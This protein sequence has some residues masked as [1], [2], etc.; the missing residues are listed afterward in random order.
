[1]GFY[2]A[3]KYK[4]FTPFYDWFITQTMPEFEIK[5]RVISLAKLTENEKVL[6]F[7][8]GTG[9]LAKMCLEHYPSIDFIGLDVDPKMIEIANNKNINGLKSVL[10]DGVTI[11]FPGHYF[12]RVL[13]TWVFH[14]LTR[15]Q[16]IIAFKEIKRVL[17]PDGLF[18]LADWGKPSN[19]LQSLLFFILQVFDTFNQTVDNVNGQIPSLIK[20]SGFMKIK[21]KGYMNTLFG[22]LRYWTSA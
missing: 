11:P 10:F 15:K 21:S 19:W 2:P 17:K 14:H 18:V 13:S 7:G 4:V 1:M 6:D 16:K 5:N 12:D 8:S 22:T 9:T 20:E 3:L